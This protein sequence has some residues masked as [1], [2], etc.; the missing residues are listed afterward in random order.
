MTTVDSAGT[1]ERRAFD[2]PTTL[3]RPRWITY[4]TLAAFGMYMAYYAVQ[5]ILIPKQTN[6]ITGNSAAAVS[7]QA[8]ANIVAAVVTIVV[9]VLAGELSDRTLHRRGRR[10]I[11]V[12]IGA[13]VFGGALIVQGIAHT[14]FLVVAFWAV[15]QVGVSSMT[16]AILAT[17]PDEVPVRQRARVSSWFGVAQSVG[18]L[19]GI[20]LV[21]TV[22][23]GVP[24]GYTALGVLV[25]LL[26]IPFALR[27]RGVRL[28][29]AQRRPLDLRAVVVGIVQPLK[30][31]DFSWAWTG[32]FFIQLSNALGQLYLYQFLKDRVHVDPDLG[33]LILTVLYTVSVVAA[34]L[35]SGWLS[36]RTGRRKRMVMISSTLQGIAGL[37]FALS[38]TMPGAIAG[39]ILLGLGYGAYISVDQALITQVLPH[40]EDRGKDLGVINIANMLP[41]VLAAALGGVVINMLGGYVTLYALVAVTGVIAALAVW[42]IKSVK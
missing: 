25:V 31:A 27:T 39:A 9:C 4:W 26:A 29:A 24:I 38:P 11:W 6:E 42:P 36:D 1:Q 18:P 16:A 33:T 12:I 41:Y 22:L 23:L 17:V 5:Q 32:R 28:T 14:V 37:I 7:A 13:L 40:P 35:P 10:Q 3:V 34:C 2:E 30:H 19:L 21:T 15:A 20:M 8:L